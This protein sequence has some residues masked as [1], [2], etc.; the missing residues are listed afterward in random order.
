MDTDSCFVEIFSKY[1]KLNIV[2]QVSNAI[3]FH[4]LLSTGQ[5]VGIAMESS[6]S[7]LEDYVQIPIRDKMELYQCG[8]CQK[9]EINTP[10]IKAVTAE[11][12][13]FGREEK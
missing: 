1:G 10:L 7:V 8:I 5:Y 6:S 2:T 4:S 11:I 13:R 12:L 9:D 3:L